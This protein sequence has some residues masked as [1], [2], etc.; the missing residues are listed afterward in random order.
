MSRSTSY[1]YDTK[2][3]RKQAR[4][5]KQYADMLSNS[6]VAKLDRTVNGLQGNFEGAAADALDKNLKETRRQ[7]ITLK[8]EINNLSS[9]LNRYANA[10]EEADRR[11]QQ[12]MGGR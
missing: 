4:E 6:A 2:A 3:I 12:L 10:L 7:V 5:V 1:N 11:A 9:A 8:N